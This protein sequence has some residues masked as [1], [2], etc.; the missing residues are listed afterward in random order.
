MKRHVVENPVKMTVIILLLVGISARSALAL[1]IDGRVVDYKARSVAGA[2][3]AVYEKVGIGGFAQDAK[4]I[5]PIVKTDS[6]GRFEV[7]ANVSSQY[8]TFI[9]ARKS[10]LALAWDGLSYSHNYKGKGLF[11]LVMEPACSLTGRLVDCDGNPVANT[12]VQIMPV[13]SYLGRL[14]QRPM[15]AP[16]EWFTTISDSQGKFHFDGFAADVG[17]SFRV[18]ARGSSSTQELRMHEQ[19]SCSYEMWRPEIRLELVKEVDVKGKVVDVYGRAVGG[20]ELM[21]CPSRLKKGITGLYLPQK[22][23]SDKDGAFVFKGITEGKSRIDILAPEKGPDLWCGKSVE[24]DVRGDKV[25]KQNTVRVDK[26]GIVEVT[27]LDEKT[28]EPIKGAEVSIYGQQWHRDKPAITDDKGVARLRAPAGE[29]TIYAGADK[30]STH[31]SKEK[32]ESGRPLRFEAKLSLLPRSYG[33]VLDP[34]GEFVSDA[35]V[36]IHPFGDHVYTDSNGRFDGGCDERRAAN[37]GFVVARDSKRSLASA[38][39]VKDWSKP[40]NIY[41]APAWTLIGKI[42]NPK[43]VGIPAARVLLCLHTQNSLSKLGVEVLTDSQGRFEMKAIPPVGDGFTYRLSIAAAGYGPKEYLRISPSGAPG[44]VVDI[45]ATEMPLANESVSGVVVDANGAPV[46]GAPIFIN[47][48]P[49][50]SQPKKS[51]ATDEKGEFAIKRLCKGKIRIQANF[52]SSP[53]GA[54]FIEAE[55]P[56]DN[57]K[58]V[59]GQTLTHEPENALIGKPLPDLKEVGLSSVELG[60]GP[61]LMCFFDMQQRPSRNCVMQLAKQAEKLK[62]KGAIV[63]AVQASK[64]DRYELDGWVE[65]QS[66]S[67][68][69]GMM[70]GD[71]MKVRFA[72]GVKSLPWLILTD[73]N[74]IVRLEG[75]AFGELDS[76][77]GGITN[78]EQ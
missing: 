26:G 68:P 25:D 27:A 28:K 31:Q 44:E 43:G 37:G 8:D 56:A 46:V 32:V 51:T 60:D 52:G 17:A 39:A 30:F 14:R 58:I 42:V 1:M 36:S 73:K 2:E 69:V 15:L 10:G 57:L 77:I 3:V 65:K 70:E 55:L 7:E 38:L 62:E 63:V 53:G 50:V 11:L 19:S 16:K 59:L 74:H 4:L 47:G 61:V 18:Q 48:L 20:I 23:T 33:R 72:W 76:K 67:F 21:I 64:I 22:T 71:E 6:A 49:G 29:Y 45:G 34:K 78:T 35:V 12:K 9:V 24:L 41:L 40:A 54:G 5:A 66:I 75:F 13:N